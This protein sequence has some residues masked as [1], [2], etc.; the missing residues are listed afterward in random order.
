VLFF[1]YGGISIQPSSVPDLTHHHH[2]EKSI[3]IISI[4]HGKP[5]RYFLI[6]SILFLL[7]PWSQVIVSTGANG[8]LNVVTTTSAAN[9]ISADKQYVYFTPGTA[10]TISFSANEPSAHL[11]SVMLYYSPVSTVNGW[12]SIASVNLSGQ[13][14]HSYSGSASWTPPGAGPYYL[15]VNVAVD[16][17]AP[18]MCSGNAVSG[19]STSYI[20]LWGYSRL[21]YIIPCGSHDVATVVSAVSGYIGNISSDK[22][23]INLGAGGPLTVSY[24]AED[25][26]NPMSSIILYASPTGSAAWTRLTQVDLVSGTTSYN[27][28]YAWTPPSNGT[29]YLSLTV[30]LTNGL[31]P[32]SGNV[33]SGGYPAATWLDAFGGTRSG[34]WL[35]C[36]GRDIARVVYDAIPPASGKNFSTNPAQGTWTNGNVTATIYAGDDTGPAWTRGINCATTAS[37]PTTDTTASS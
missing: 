18:T 13:N 9:T 7:V 11:T 8:S 5:L 30:G 16:G 4:P 19:N 26:G 27:G 1:H 24:H 34:A 31:V 3:K 6:F 36:S 20:D 2:R 32:C 37:V 33:T 12:V 21:G 10:M 25:S 29:Y 15:V 23:T 35:P 28:S 22:Q 17:S 14:L